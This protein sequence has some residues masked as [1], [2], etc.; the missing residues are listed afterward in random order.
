MQIFARWFVLLKSFSDLFGEAVHFGFVC[1]VFRSKKKLVHFF[2]LF[3]FAPIDL[4]LIC[5]NDF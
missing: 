1:F 2:V 4:P 3:C 5:P